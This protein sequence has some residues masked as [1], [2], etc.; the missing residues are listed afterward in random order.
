[1]SITCDQY[2]ICQGHWRSIH[3]GTKSFVSTNNIQGR[4]QF[5]RCGMSTLCE[6]A[7]RDYYITEVWSGQC[8][9]EF[10]WRSTREAENLS[11][12][13]CLS[14]QQIRRI[15][16]TG[17]SS[18]TVIPQT[19]NPHPLRAHRICINL[20]NNTWIKMG[21][22]VH[23]SLSV[24]KP[25]ITARIILFFLWM[26]EHINGESQINKIDKKIIKWR[27]RDHIASA[28]PRWSNRRSELSFSTLTTLT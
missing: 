3:I 22:H 18:Q 14:E 7:V 19:P 16:E 5:K 20:R 17:E 28:K 2:A 15:L 27:E 21:G 24:A 8:S 23:P 1:M 4:R 13:R 12:F 6:P 25:L 26:N 9:H 11:P 10:R